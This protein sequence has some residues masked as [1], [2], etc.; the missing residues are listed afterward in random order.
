MEYRY[1]DHTADVGVIGQGSTPSEAL[2]ALVRGVLNL[3][4]GDA[5]VAGREEEVVAAEGEEEDDRL[6]RFLNELLFLVE[7]RRWLPASVVEL[8]WERDRIEARLA[9]EPFDPDRHELAS[10]VK[11]ATYHQLRFGPSGEGWEVQVIFDV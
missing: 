4:V 2:E 5:P 9:G 3:I 8:R 6:V 1:L 7:G 11:A 10:E